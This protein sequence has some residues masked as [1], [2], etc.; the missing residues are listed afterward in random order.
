MGGNVI[1]RKIDRTGEE[2]L[3]NFGSRMIIKEYRK[4][5]DIDVYFP[6]YNWTFKHARYDHFKDRKIKCP[7]E[8]R[9]YGKG[10]LGEGK[11]KVREN[12]K[13]TDEF[14]I[15]YRMLQRCYDPKLNEKES[16]Y[17]GCRAEN[18]WLNFQNMAEWI[19]NNY[20]E[21]PGEV[22]H[23][24]KDILCKGNK[25]YSRKT[26][27]FVP[28]RI[29]ELFTKRDN[30]RGKDPIGVDQLPSGNYQ[31]RC[32]DGNGK[33]IYLGSYSTKE[34]AFQV[35]KEYKES[36][37]KGTIDEYKGKIPEPHYSKLR[38][39]MYNYKVEIDD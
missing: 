13:I 7:Y 38:E 21:V 25:V 19:E 35:Y 26:C 30:A 6:E 14:N 11:Y 2:R 3:N 10:Y 24:D 29:N 20:Y 9:L 18:D 1:V 22:M 5:D 33:K 31:V 36:L 27:I 34:E 37:I 17:K 4:R 8:P 32:N 23:L 28:E 12:G 39:A 15:W 16:T